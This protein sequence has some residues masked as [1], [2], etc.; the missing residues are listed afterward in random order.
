[1][2]L[3]ALPNP[4]A[5]AI[6]RHF[7]MQEIRTVEPL[8]NCRSAGA[9]NSLSAMMIDA[10][11]Y[12]L[13]YDQGLCAALTQQGCKVT[14]ARSQDLYAQDEFEGPFTA[15]KGFYPRAHA[16]AKTHSRGRL[17][18]IAKAGE[19]GLSMRRLTAEVERS[20]PAIVHFQWLP[21]PLLDQIFLSR[22]HRIAPLV[23]TLHNTSIFH[24][25]NAY[26]LYG[27]GLRSAFKRFDAVIAHTEYSKQKAIEQK[28]IDEDRIHV[29]PHGVMSH[30][31]QLGTGLSDVRQASDAEPIILFFGNLKHYKGVDVL[32]H[33]F[34]R[35]TIGVR[36]TTK[37][38]IV[39]YPGMDVAPLRDSAQR[40]GVA[41]RIKWDLRFVPEN[42]IPAIF[43]S[44]SVVVL[45][46]REID[47]SGVLLTAIALDKAVVA[48]RIGGISETIQDGIHGFIVPPE[49][50]DSMAVAIEKI[51]TS[52]DLRAL[53][54]A[55]MH[56]LGQD[57]AW[58]RIARKTLSLYRALGRPRG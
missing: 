41:E 56:D 3:N 32:I 34:S 19:H 45:P 23:L 2:K 46:Y 20:R 9:V 6:P 39:G 1:M 50:P 38:H 48:T 51:V 24:G 44:A 54:E 33:A 58:D 47:Q 27:L 15:W 29:I 28:W 52:S 43:A 31:R 42:E 25:N 37:L 36:Q 16:Y 21:L 7:K 10:S 18:R 22:L 17:W 49:A 55:A 5:S 35:L 13:A 30:Y 8:S 12:S 57:L 40:L 14:L 11:N 4:Q 26:G 53:M